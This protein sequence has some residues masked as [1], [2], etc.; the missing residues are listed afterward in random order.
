MRAG[1]HSTL[2]SISTFTSR[3]PGSADSRSSAARTKCGAIV[4]APKVTHRR[5]DSTPSDDSDQPSSRPMSYRLT[6]VA[7]ATLQGS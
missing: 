2:V 6:G 1:V 7:A 3:T 4:Q 5:T